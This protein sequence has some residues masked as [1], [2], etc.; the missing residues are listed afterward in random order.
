MNH[1]GVQRKSGKGTKEGE[2]MVTPHRK[3]KEF[4]CAILCDDI[5]AV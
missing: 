2:S 3:F 4:T 1:G 5:V